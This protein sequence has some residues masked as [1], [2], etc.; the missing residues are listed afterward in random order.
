MFGTQGTLLDSSLGEHKTVEAIIE[1]VGMSQTDGN[2]YYTLVLKDYPELLLIGAGTIS[3]ELPI[4][5]EGDLVNIEY[6]DGKNKTKTIVTFDNLN[7]N[8]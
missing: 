5:R 6:I 3:S 7:F 4:S 8:Q 2:T 1:R